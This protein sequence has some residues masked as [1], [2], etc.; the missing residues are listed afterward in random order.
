MKAQKKLL[1][2]A[3]AVAILAAAAA[4]GGDEIPKAAWKRPI[5]E[6]LA[7]PGTKKASLEATHIDDGYWQGVPVGGFGA[8]ALLRTY[9]GNFARWHMK[10]GVHKYQTVDVDQFSMFQKA[11]GDAQG[12]ARV[13][14]AGHPSG[15]ALKSWAWDYPVG[16]GD[17]YALYPKSW[18]DYRWD[19][20]PAHVTLEQFSPVLPDNYKETSYPVAIYRWHA[21][22]PASKKVTVSVMLTWENMAGVFRTFSRDLSGTSLDGNRDHAD[23]EALGPAGMMTGIVFDRNH[24][25]KSVQED[26]DG[27]M[28]IA[29]MNT[30]GVEVSYMNTFAAD[31]DGSDVWKPFAANGTLPNSDNTWTSN[32]E[33]LAGAIAVKF[34]LEPGEKKVV[35]MVIAWDH[36]GNYRSSMYMRSAA[37]WAM[38]MLKPATHGTK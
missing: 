4:R 1:W 5:G 12:T 14:M 33:R 37:I 28:V 25:G 29:A 2:A 38:E 19:K 10:A 23:K 27:Q 32:G 16:A 35:P 6:P 22:N 9:R 30:P 26:W 11:E 31:G 34:T 21:E 7:N 13:L 17:Y 15:K 36:T 8:G 24:V 20:F 3:F 18:F